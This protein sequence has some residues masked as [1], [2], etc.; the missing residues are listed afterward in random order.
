[1]TSKGGRP[2]N[3]E[4]TKAKVSRYFGIDHRTLTKL[5][6]QQI[7]LFEVYT[8]FKTLPTLRE[9]KEFLYSKLKNRYKGKTVDRVDRIW[10]HYIEKYEA[11]MA[12]LEEEYH[13]SNHTTWQS[14]KRSRTATSR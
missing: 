13:E 9:R 5:S 7:N 6:H 3:G 12:K 1:M 8:A 11:Y 4:L 2:K 14:Y 10:E